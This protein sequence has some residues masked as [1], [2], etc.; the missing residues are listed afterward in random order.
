MF[1]LQLKGNGS[2]INNEKG[3]S[4]GAQNQL[5][6]AAVIESGTQEFVHD[7]GLNLLIQQLTFLNLFV[8]KLFHTC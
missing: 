1:T 5:E 8:Y 6:A 3:Q 2:G 4:S 7:D